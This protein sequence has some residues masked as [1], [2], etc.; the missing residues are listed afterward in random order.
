[1]DVKQI[2]KLARDCV[3]AETKKACSISYSEILKEAGIDQL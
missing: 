1:M 3:K 2:E